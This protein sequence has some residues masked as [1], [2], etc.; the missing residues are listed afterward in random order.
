MRTLHSFKNA[1]TALR[2]NALRSSLTILGIVIGIAG[3]M[4][5]MSV[6]QGARTLILR[7]IS[8][9]GAEMIVI[10][11]GREPQ[12]PSDIAQTLFADSLKERDVK[13][14]KDK[15]RV[16]DLE[17]VSPAVIVPG[18]VSYKGETFRPTMFGWSAELIGDMLQVYPEQGTV[19]SENDIRRRAKV[20]VIGH[21]VAKEL[22]GNEN[23]IGKTIKIKNKSFRVVGVYPSKG[24]VAFFNIDEFV[25]LPYSTAQ[26]YLLGIDYYN[27]I[28]AKARSPETVVWAVQDIKRTLREMHGITDPKKDDFYVVTQEGVVGRVS[29]IV[30]IIT[31]FLSAVVSVA[32]VVGGIGVMNIMLVS[33]AE[34]TREIGLRKA[35]G[36]TEKDIKVQ[37]LMEAIILAGVGGVIGILLGAGFAYLIAVAAREFAGL[38]WEFVFPVWAAV[39][40]FLASAGVGLIF[41]IYPARQAAK[42]DPIVALRYE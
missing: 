3:I 6:G 28:I 21:K 5:I 12:G 14:L 18:S 29:S 1:L 34:R 38:E 10:R 13:A 36:A 27:E 41:G 4:L 35:L 26:K 24:Q 19:F 8:G 17:V 23:P 20:A 11:P 15:N 2:T 40:G 39:I 7:E 16:P 25:L 30:Q 31:L 42:K 32:L 33:V 22:F 37:F 9:F